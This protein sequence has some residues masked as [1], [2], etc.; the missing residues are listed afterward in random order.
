MIRFAT[1]PIRAARNL[2]LDLILGKD[3]LGPDYVSP[4]VRQAMDGPA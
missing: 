1:W 3:E 2:A 4:T